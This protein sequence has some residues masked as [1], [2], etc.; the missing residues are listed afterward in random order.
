MSSLSAPAPDV[1]RVGKIEARGIEYVEPRDRIGRVRDLF[2]VFF[3]AEFCYAIMFFGALPLAFGLGWWSSVAAITVGL[4]VGS[5]VFAPM[6]LF[7]PRTGTNSTVS[8]VAHF[9][10]LGRIVGSAAT[11]LTAFIFVILTL[12]TG[13]SALEAGFHRLIGTPTGTLWLVLGIVV[14]WLLTTAL[15]VLGHATLVANFKFVALTCGVVILAMIP[16]FA[17]HFHA[18]PNSGEYALGSF[19]P[20]WILAATIAASVPISY[21]PVANDYARYVPAS[22]S[23]RSVFL[24]SFGGM[25]I[26]CWIALVIGAFVT[27]AFTKPDPAGDFVHGLMASSPLWFVIF[28]I[29]AG[30]FGNVANGALALYNATLDLHAIVWRLRRVWVAVIV[31]AVAFAGTILGTVV[32][33]GVST[34]EALLSVMIV[35]VAPWML[36]NT[37]G[38]LHCGGNYRALDLHAFTWDGSDGRGAYWFAGGLEIRAF[39]AWIVAVAV[40]MLFIATTLITGPL[41]KHVGGMDFSF[42]TSLVAGGLVYELLLRL[43]PLAVVDHRPDPL[44]VRP[45]AAD[46]DVAVAGPTATSI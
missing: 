29:Y 28:L 43:T 21:G 35:T 3:A 32:W 9:G 6:A 40:G 8:S 20:T 13:G 46:G 19:W 44:A 36:I 18:V 38:Y 22:A 10:V 26:G 34:L 4:A 25:F 12:W 14:I 33:D 7:G 39:V 5:L 1:N 27:A 23:A 45:T 17:S 11:Q 15:T 42:L 30:V 41:V 31:G 37:I 24:S 2:S 16:V